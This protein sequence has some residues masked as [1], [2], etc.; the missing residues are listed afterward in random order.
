MLVDDRQGDRTL[1]GTK[2]I[3]IETTDTSIHWMEPRDRLCSELGK[4]TDQGE[5]LAGHHGGACVA[6]AD[7]TI[8]LLDAIETKELVT[9]I[10]SQ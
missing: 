8:E 2:C 4:E 10:L 6:H 3:V 9:D 1:N 7:G 5:S